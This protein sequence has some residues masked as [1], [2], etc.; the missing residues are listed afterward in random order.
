MRRLG[1]NIDHV[2][3]IRNARGNNHPDTLFAAKLAMKYGADA[4]T[5]HLREDRRHIKDLDVKILC[6]NKNIPINLEIGSNENIL[7]IALKYKPDY[8][9]IVPEKRKEITTEGGLN[10]SRNKNKIKRMISKLNKNK[11]RT[12]LF[13]NANTKNI[14][15]AKKLN[16]DCV[17]LHTGKL[18]DLIK[19][20]KN[21]FNELNKIKSSSKLARSIGLEVHAGHGI[22]FQSIKVLNKINEI[23]EFNIG[24]FIIGQSI[25]D[26]FKMVIEK[27]IKL[28][29]N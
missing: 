29:N 24:H 4:I 21:Y 7:K 14:L 17:E 5:I 20:K 26:G 12:T 13:I 22:D 2:A 3:T 1:V 6:K 10:L 23:E 16:S 19:S 11:I 25:F 18:T 9:C 15:L 28:S 8:V 27:F